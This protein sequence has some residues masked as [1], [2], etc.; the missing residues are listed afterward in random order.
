MPDGRDEEAVSITAKELIAAF[1]GRASVDASEAAQLAEE[2]GEKE[3]VELWWAVVD[4]IR[5]IQG[6]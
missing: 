2:A 3:E 4:K 1:G 6:A 5:Q